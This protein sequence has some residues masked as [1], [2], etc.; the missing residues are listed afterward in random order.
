M[1][2]DNIPS[3]NQSWG[4]PQASG[5]LLENFELNKTPAQA[6][7][8]DPEDDKNKDLI[9]DGGVNSGESLLENKN[10]P[11]T[12][13][14]TT[15]ATPEG[16][17]TPTE[18]VEVPKDVVDAINSLADTGIIDLFESR[19][20]KTIEDVKDLIAANI[21]EKISATN[22]NIFQEQLSALPPQFQ[23]II[24]Y[25]LD[26]GTNVQQL[27]QQWA[28]TEQAFSID[29]T[30]DEGKAEAIRQYL[31][32]TNYGTPEVINQ[33]IE[34][35]KGLNKLDEKVAI[36][37]PKLEQF[38]VEQVKNIEREAATEALQEQAYHANYT[39]AVGR[40]LSEDNL[41]GL[42]LPNNV[43]Q[44]VYE[45]TQPLYQSQL[46]GRPIDALQAV[47]EELKFGQ[48]ANPAFYAELLLHATQPEMYR[49]LF[50]SR[51]K[52]NVAVNTE[53]KLRS[54]AARDASGGVEVQKTTPKPQ[55]ANN[56]QRW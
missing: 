26:G 21:E 51:M 17:S 22:E 56:T 46:T 43:K 41:N 31:T 4:E 40:T 30:T 29:T 38:H 42:V 54:S 8:D 37:K 16:N 24:N 44:F 10:N 13:A 12:P 18:E 7:L 34:T 53:R 28:A 52:E 15:P 25:G 35:W 49:E 39:E 36:F 14:A 50:S 11:T 27:V 48:N 45:N 55:P 1:A 23:S 32:L 20:I 19:E 5:S 33:D 2:F 47:V 3:A 6:G 9:P